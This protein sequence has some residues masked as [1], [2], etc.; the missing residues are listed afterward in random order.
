MTIHHW[1]YHI[2]IQT[3]DITMDGLVEFSLL[4][5]LLE[6]MMLTHMLLVINSVKPIGV[7]MPNSPNLKTDSILVTWTQDPQR[8]GDSGT[9][10]WLNVEDGLSGD[11]L[12]LTIMEEHGLGS[13]PNPTLTVEPSDSTLLLQCDCHIYLF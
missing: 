2:K 5:H 10:N 3:E 9:G 4:L 8:L 11:T 13:I 6:V 7:K 1:Q 12:T